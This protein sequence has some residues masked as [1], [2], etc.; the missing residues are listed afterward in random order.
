MSDRMAKVLFWCCVPFAPFVAAGIV[1]LTIYLVGYYFLA[2]E[3]WLEAIKLW[4]RT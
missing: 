2:F 3:W 4:L 1:G